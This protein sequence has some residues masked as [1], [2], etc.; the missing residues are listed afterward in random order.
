[1]VSAKKTKENK[2]RDEITMKQ[3]EKGGNKKQIFK[4]FLQNT[5]EP[6]R[7]KRKNKST[8]NPFI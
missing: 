2:M 6:K 3:K 8:I 5:Q 1:L 7:K 4:N